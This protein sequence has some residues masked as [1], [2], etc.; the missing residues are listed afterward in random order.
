MY[1]LVIIVDTKN[2]KIK[3]VPTVL[4]LRQRNR[5]I[6]GDSTVIHCYCTYISVEFIHVYCT[7]TPPLFRY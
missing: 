3:A 1:V 6:R 2:F 5:T 4:V 7:E